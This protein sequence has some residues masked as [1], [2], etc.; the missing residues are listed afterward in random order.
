MTNLS[1]ADFRLIA[2]VISLLKDRRTSPSAWDEAAARTGMS[3][4]A[5]RETF[6]RWAGTDVQRFMPFVDKAHIAEVLRT[7]RLSDGCR[8]SETTGS[9]RQ[10]GPAVRI[11][12]MS[13][14]E[15]RDGGR[16]LSIRY[17]FAESPFG[18]V[19]TASTR[20]GLCYMAFSDDR[21]KTLGELRTLF[22][23]AACLH[24]EDP[25]QRDALAVFS[26]GP[27]DGQPVKLHLAGTPFRLKVWHALLHIPPG[28]LTTYGEL[29]RKIGCP[30]AS[31]AVGTAVGAN[32]VSYLVPCHRVVRSSGETGEYHWGADRKT[33]MIGWEAVRRAERPNDPVPC[34]GIRE[35]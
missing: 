7:R 33:A 18:E 9:E 4:D 27:H 5:L 22:P 19:L 29:A 2:G 15:C 14:D 8:T 25:F 3:R 23:A 30:G 26:D 1:A 34:P 20:K 24:G 35:P 12:A 13:S 21:Q 16:N 32:P 28:A 10:S 6:V 11:E 17:A 31:R